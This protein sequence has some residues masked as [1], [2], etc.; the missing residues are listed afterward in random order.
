MS[1]NK[2][3]KKQVTLEMSKNERTIKDT[4]EADS[5]QTNSMKRQK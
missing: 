2:K 4:L 1:Y 3:K 5:Y